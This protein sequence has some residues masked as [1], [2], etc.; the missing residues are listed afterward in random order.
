MYGSGGW[1]VGEWVHVCLGVGVDEWGRCLG[2]R[3][4]WVSGWVGVCVSGGVCMGEYRGLG[5]CGGGCRWMGE[6]VYVWMY[7]WVSGGGV[8]GMGI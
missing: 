7:V 3:C 4:G 6:W 2:C 8:W 1:G 5:V